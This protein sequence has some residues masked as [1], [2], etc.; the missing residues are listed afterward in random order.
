MIEQIANLTMKG[1]IIN[2][3]VED[4]TN[5]TVYSGSIPIDKNTSS[6]FQPTLIK[7]NCEKCENGELIFDPSKEYTETS[8]THSCSNCDNS[9]V[10][11]KIYPDINLAD[12]KTLDDISG[13]TVIFDPIFKEKE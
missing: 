10:F 1:L 9:E 5:R 3:Q 8:F 4:G 13:F 2:F 11:D 6:K 12:Q 7:A